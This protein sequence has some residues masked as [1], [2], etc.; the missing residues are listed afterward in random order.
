[1]SRHVFFDLDGTLTDPQLGITR[2]IQYA[3]EQLGEPVPASEDLLWCIGPPL[4]GNFEVLVGAQRAADGVRLYRERF[5][6]V[7]LYENEPYPNI[8]ATLMQ[9]LDQGTVLHVASS[10]PRIYVEQI[11]A[12]F[13][14]EHFFTN[15]YG[16]ELDGTRTDKTEL[17]AYALDHAGLVAHQCLMVG[18]RKHDAVGA[19]NNQLEFIGVLYGYGDRAE[20]A[21]V[22]ECRLVESHSEIPVLLA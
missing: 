6:Q 5:A 11:L 4:L 16:S 8:Q 7:G 14:L 19:A 15:V 22:G 12:H 2:C 18:D 1:L 3:L 21:S 10:K 20:F 17:L 13:E 9:L